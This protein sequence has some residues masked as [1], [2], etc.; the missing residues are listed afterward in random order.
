MTS[1]KSKV[2]W[3][4]G[5]EGNPDRVILLLAFPTITSYNSILIYL[6]NP[7]VLSTLFYP[8]PQAWSQKPSFAFIRF[9]T[10]ASNE[11][12]PA[13]KNIR[14]AL[15]ILHSQNHA[16]YQMGKWECQ[17]ERGERGD[18]PLRGARVS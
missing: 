13:S 15:R 16:N 11:D 4:L 17:R 9:A 10:L 14:A 18:E 6:L 2:E 3:W 8:D 7:S 12:K 5:R 1:S